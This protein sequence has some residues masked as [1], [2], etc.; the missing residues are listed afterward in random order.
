MKNSFKFGKEAL[1]LAVMTTATIIT[2]LAFDIYRASKR[3]TIAETTKE[4]M[5]L[6][7]PKINKEIINLLKN[8]LSPETTI[9]ES[10]PEGTSLP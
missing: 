10:T 3:I 6:L 4:Q 7:D 5:K 8:S 9:P 2:W 1:V